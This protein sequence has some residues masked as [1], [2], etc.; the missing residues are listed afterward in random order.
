MRI[1]STDEWRL[2]LAEPEYERRMPLRERKL[3]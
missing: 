2:F 3:K 1:L